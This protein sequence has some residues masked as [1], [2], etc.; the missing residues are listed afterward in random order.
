MNAGLSLKSDPRSFPRSAFGGGCFATLLAA[1]LVFADVNGHILFWCSV[2][3]FA[4]ALLLCA[5]KKHR[6]AVTVFFWCFCVLLSTV[7]SEQVRFDTE[8]YALRLIRA[9]ED[10]PHTFEARVT[11]GNMNAAGNLFVE[12]LS[13]DG[14][15]LARPVRA[16]T[17]NRSGHFAAEGSRLGFTASL[18]VPQNR[19]DNEFDLVGWLRGKTVYTT[20]SGFSDVTPVEITPSAHKRLQDLFMTGIEEA[21][22]TI[23]TKAEYTRTRALLMG[24][25][26]GDKSGFTS[27]DKDMFSGSGI[28][29]ILCVSGLHFSLVLGGIGFLASFLIPRRRARLLLLSLLSFLYLLLCGFSVSAI[30]AAVMS[31]FSGFGFVSDP[32]R[33]TDGVLGA[34]AVMCLVSPVTVLD[35]GFR[36]SVLSCVGIAL[37]SGLSHALEHRLERTPALCFIVGSLLLSTAAY[38]ATGVYT[39]L[40]FG[41]T[42]LSWIVASFLAV[43]PA[44]VCLGAGFLAAV[45]V[46]LFPGLAAPFGSVFRLLTEMIFGVAEYFSSLPY[47]VQTTGGQ[48]FGSVWFFFILALGALAVGNKAKGARLC[49]WMLVITLGIFVVL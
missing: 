28:T 42:A 36:L 48:T 3:G 20:L 11:D 13:V 40:V 49:L 34:A 43:L 9:L 29:H 7:R 45:L 15:A 26:T 46:P 47:T 6:R 39:A 24:L 4:V 18:T 38:A 10:K 8:H 31:L 21:L 19:A 35:I 12:L 14:K 16:Y 23:P 25:T 27:E 22:N 2:C 30:R 5:L 17:Y 33:C 44:Q 1:A 37:F 32:R 41:G